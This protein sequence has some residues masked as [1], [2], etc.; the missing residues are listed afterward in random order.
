METH[1]RF[2]PSRI[3]SRWK[4]AVRCGLMLVPFFS[5]LAGGLLL[6]LSPVR[7]RS[8]ALVEFQNSPPAPELAELLES[9]ANLT[10]VN[11]QLQLTNLLSLDS[12]TVV[13]V[14]REAIEV[15]VVPDT[16]LL[17]VS[18]TLRQKDTARDTAAQLV[19]SLRDYLTGIVTTA[20]KTKADHLESL[21]A[22]ATE[23]AEEQTTKV[24]NLEKLHSPAPADA[25][26]ATLLLRARRAALL[27]DAEVERLRT[28]RNEC[29]TQNLDALPRLVV[30]S[31]PVAS[32]TPCSPQVGPAFSK[33]IG[34]SLLLGLLTALVLPYLMELAFPPLPAHAA[35]APD[36]TDQP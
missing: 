7:Y 2:L 29:L 30:H 22:H 21:I 17:E 16:R 36:F 18:V 25:A 27:A 26:P 19:R 10:A 11:D 34:R 32:Q 4:W 35:A 14:L 6:Y 33:L 12:D 13:A 31:D 9:R 28:L 3:Y 24:A 20:G 8:T 15:N 23:F 5:F 1:A